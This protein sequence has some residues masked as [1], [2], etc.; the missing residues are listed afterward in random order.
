MRTYFCVYQ[1]HL[2]DAGADINHADKDGRTALSVAALCV[3]AS[4]GHHAAVVSLLLER[5][6]EVRGVSVIPLA[7]GNWS[8]TKP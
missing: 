8:N 7:K 4:Q 2:L 6:A 1:G 3:P 5:G